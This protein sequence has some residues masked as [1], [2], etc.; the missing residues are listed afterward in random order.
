MVCAVRGLCDVRDFHLCCLV[1]I[2][3][4]IGCE[5][6]VLSFELKVSVDEFLF[7]YCRRRSVFISCS[8][9]VVFYS[10]FGQVV[11]CRRACGGQVRFGG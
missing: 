11:S 10:H 7:G 1:A 4:D 8:V 9:F 6:P 2:G 3:Y 5:M